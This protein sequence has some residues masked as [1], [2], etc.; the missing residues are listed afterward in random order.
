MS[1][2]ILLVEDEKHL[3]EVI[4]DYFTAKSEGMIEVDVFEN[5]KE[6]LLT[7]ETEDY[8][9]ILLDVMLPGVDGFTVCR[10][11]RKNSNVPIIFITARHSEEDR[12]YGYGLGCDDYIVKPFSLPELYAKVQ[13]WIRRSKG[14]DKG[15]LITAGKITLDKY[16]L[17]CKVNGEEVM[18]SPKEFALLKALIENKGRSVTRDD[19]IVKI[20]GYD[21]DGNDRVVDNH[22]RKLRA[23]LGEASEQIKTVTKTGYRL[24]E[25]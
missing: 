2:R 13:A 4:C 9:L 16:R 5:G 10:Q 6:A 25:K 19:L 20:W 14:Q 7:A 12:L 8:D 23:H 21:F 15:E 17:T 1:F 3:Q 18:L 24:E 22:I 11:V